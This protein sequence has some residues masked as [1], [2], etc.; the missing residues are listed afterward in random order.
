MMQFRLVALLMMASLGIVVS[1]PLGP[2]EPVKP[3]AKAIPAKAPVRPIATMK[4]KGAGITL[5]L[6]VKAQKGMPVEIQATTTGK[7][8]RWLVMD[9][10]LALIPPHL[11]KDSKTALVWA[12][13][14]GV[15]RIAAYTVI[16]GEPTEAAVCVVTIGRAVPRPKPNPPDPKPDPDV[17]PKDLPFAGVEPAGLRVLIIEES[18]ER[19]KLT[20]QQR[21]ILLSKTVREYLDAKT[22]KGKGPGGVPWSEWR[23]YDK[24]QDVSQD[25]EHFKRAMGRDRKDKDGQPGKLPWLLIGNGVS[26]YDGPLPA[27]VADTMTLL[28]KHGG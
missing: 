22:V 9:E 12:M 28:R 2:P 24:D 20:S 27:N 8:V 6:D 4:V 5:P 15:Y 26:G 13:E 21:L 14:E 18:S 3:I 11:L 1:A 19:P 17:T 16:D 25:S 7:M 23:I 10:G